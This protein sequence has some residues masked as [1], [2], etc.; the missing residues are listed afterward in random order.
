MQKVLSPGIHIQHSFDSPRRANLLRKRNCARLYRRYE[1]CRWTLNA[2]RM[3][4]EYSINQSITFLVLGT[5]Q[6]GS[7]DNIFNNVGSLLGPAGGWK[8]EKDESNDIGT[9]RGL[10]EDRGIHQR[11]ASACTA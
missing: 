5:H 3:L 1:V 10:T 6:G 11:V 7:T 9:N 2:Q 8:M 4:A